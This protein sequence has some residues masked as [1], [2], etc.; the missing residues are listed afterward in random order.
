MLEIFVLG[1]G[2]IT[3]AVVTILLMTRHR[4]T[5]NDGYSDGFS[6]RYASANYEGE[7]AVD[8]SVKSIVDVKPTRVAVKKTVIIK[9]ACAATYIIPQVIE[10]MHEDIATVML[11]KKILHP[12]VHS[13]H[14]TPQ[15]ESLDI[16]IAGYVA[17]DPAASS[18]DRINHFK[19]S[20]VE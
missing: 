10:K 1:I 8:F 15:G 19:F 7:L 13:R 14:K 3:G 2:Y 17:P 12:V 18:L 5:Y 16:E 6:Q 11:A 20:K 9:D 4:K